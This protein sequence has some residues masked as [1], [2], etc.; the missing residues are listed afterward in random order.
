MSACVR[1]TEAAEQTVSEFLVKGAVCGG[2]V[3]LG[4]KHPV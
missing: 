1:V 2:L 4:G 3:G